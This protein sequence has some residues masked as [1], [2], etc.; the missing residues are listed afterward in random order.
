[1][2]ELSDGRRI[3]WRFGLARRG[4][5]PEITVRPSNDES[6]HFLTEVPEAEAEDAI[7]ALT[8]VTAIK[9]ESTL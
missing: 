3:S 7:R 4:V 5:W 2:I 8:M 6:L 1:M 9:W